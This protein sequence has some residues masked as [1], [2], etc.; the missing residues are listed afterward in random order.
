MWKGH[1]RSSIEDKKD[2]KDKLFYKQNT[3]YADYHEL[4]NKYLA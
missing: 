4:K 3:D 1:P 2:K